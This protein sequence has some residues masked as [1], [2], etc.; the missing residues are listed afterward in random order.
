MTDFYFI[1]VLYCYN[2]NLS[3]VHIKKIKLKK[4]TKLKDDN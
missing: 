3:R 4:T 2:A 1:L